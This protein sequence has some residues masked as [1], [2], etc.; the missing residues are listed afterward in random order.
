[1]C[2]CHAEFNDRHAKLHDAIMKGDQEN[3]TSLL[4]VHPINDPIT[5]WKYCALFP[6]LPAQGLAIL[7][8]HLAA[9]YRKAKSLQCL[10]QLKADIETRDAMGRTALHLIIVHW[11]NIIQDWI[12]PKTKFEKAMA[13][14]QSRAESCLQLLC[15]HGVQ[16]NATTQG[17]SRDTAMH[18]AV[19]HG[20]W[21]AVSIL[22]RHGADL[23]AA[24]QHGM[25][26]LHMASGL[27]N[28]R[29]MEELLGRGA[30]VDS[31]VASSGS[32]PLQLAVHAASSKGGQQLGAGLDCVRML[33]AAGASVDT[34]DRQGRTAVHEACFGGW[35]ELIDLLLEYD[36]DLGLRT[37]Q[38]ESPLSLFLE[39]RP[40]LHCSHL[41]AKLLS[42]SCPLRIASGEGGR[43]PCGLL[44]PEFRWHREFLLALSQ[45][46]PALRDLCRV[47]IRK[48]YGYRQR[49]H[50]KQILPTSVWQFV[51]GHQDY[52]KRLAEIMVKPK[53]RPDRG[54]PGELDNSLLRMHL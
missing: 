23:E 14:M 51:Y 43:L 37:E 4:K 12:V 22:A 19:R 50:L 7:P 27:L 10:L 47:A 21:P 18:L 29:M 6:T 11:P 34:Q 41:L 35:E 42:L 13:A 53:E 45:E 44:S 17:R 2:E 36:A 20:A 38:G 40:N 9:T 24:D 52:T 31:R 25:T 15:Q 16:V 54:G 48:V 30:R 3:I 8:I 39:R 28:Q 33:L 1:M 26:P 5:I 32:T 46:P 49:Q